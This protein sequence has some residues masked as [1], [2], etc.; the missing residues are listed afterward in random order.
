MAA[1]GAM[2]MRAAIERDANAGMTDPGGQPVPPDFQPH[3][4]GLPCRTWFE[5]R[6][7]ITQDIRK[8]IVIE[9]RRMVVPLATDIIEDDRVV[10]V[11]DRLGSEIFSGSARI[12]S[13]GR[14]QDHLA[15]LLQKVD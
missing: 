9:E 7:E 5:Q 15:L 11:T 6:E 4:S 8:N 14:R 12:E 10:Q 3:L 13:V 2:N 1:R